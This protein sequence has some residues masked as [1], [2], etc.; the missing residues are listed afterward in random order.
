MVDQM[1]SHFLVQIN[2]SIG[3]PNVT[4]NS[5]YGNDV[6]ASRPKDQAHGEVQP[7]DT[8]WFYCTRDV[9]GYSMSLALGA[10][11]THVTEDK[12]DLR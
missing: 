5:Q 11:V 9:P 10:S 3:Y 12:A 4:Q 7:G 8:L 2:C 6:W 1:P